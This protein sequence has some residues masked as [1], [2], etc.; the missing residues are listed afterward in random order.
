MPETDAAR[1]RLLA[2]H[3][4]AVILAGQSPSGAYIASPNFPVYRYSWLRDGAFIADAMSRAG[5]VASAEAFFGWCARV[6]DARADRVDALIGRARRGERIPAVDH[7]HTRYTLD[8]D[9]SDAEWWNFQLDGYGA[10]LWALGEH[11]HRH[12]RPAAPF[13]GGAHV[14]ARYIEAFWPEASYDWWEERPEERHVSTLA[15]LSAGLRAAAELPGIDGEAAAGFGSSAAA[16]H[17]TLRAEADRLGYLPKWLGGNAVDASLLAVGAPFG[18]FE[19]NDPAVLATVARIETELV[20]RGGVHRYLTDTYYGGGEWLLLAGFLGLQYAA[21]GRSEEARAQLAWIADHATADG[22]LP[23]Q[24]TDHLLAPE[25]CAEW[26][27]RWGPV[28]TPLLWSHAMYLSLAVQLGI[29]TSGAAS[30]T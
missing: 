16:I 21:N 14:S 30:I 11:L 7:L 10:W 6:L 23:E 27:E 18:V 17:A 26:L 19:P 9:E 22:L 25:R 5:E 20:H 2:T 24:V 1:L 15:A 29:A 28:A 3:S 4:V 8:G 12:R 13:V